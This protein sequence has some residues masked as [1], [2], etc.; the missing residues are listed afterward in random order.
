MNGTLARILVVVL[1]ALSV[2]RVAASPTLGLISIEIE[3]WAY[4]PILEDEGEVQAI[5]AVRVDQSG[6]VSALWCEPEQDSTW[7]ALAWKNTTAETIAAY[8]F[9]VLGAEVEDG[10]LEDM[11]YTWPVPLDP[12]LVLDAMDVPMDPLP[13]GDG[14]FV[15]DPVEPF[16]QANPEL[17]GSLESIGYPAIASISD[18][19]I[20]GG[21]FTGNPINPSPI[22]D[23]CLRASELLDVLKFAFESSSHDHLIVNAAFHNESLR[24]NSTCSCR[25]RTVT[26]SDTGWTDSCGPWI[27]TGG[28]TAV[29][30]DCRYS[31]QR[32]VQGTQSRTRR[33]TYADC[34]T[35]D[36]TQVRNRTGIQTTNTIEVRSPGTQCPA[37]GLPPTQVACRCS[38]FFLC[39]EGPWVPTKCPWE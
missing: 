15:G 18:S 20:D 7:S 12:I 8:A 30:T 39:Q 29:G 13:F 10:S 6:P 23:G 33:H 14:V 35:E 28:P 38:G 5:V 9:H 37:A 27:Q 17:L 22:G 16:V 3:G 34:S 25:E 31:W 19:T 36:C 32:D 2:T 24:I 26:L 4:I 11:I 21:T 1:L